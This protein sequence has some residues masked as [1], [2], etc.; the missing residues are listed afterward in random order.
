L[1]STGASLP[2]PAVASGIS[3]TT[4]GE[5]SCEGRDNQETTVRETEVEERADEYPHEEAPEEEQSIGENDDTAVGRERQRKLR[6]SRLGHL[7]FHDRLAATGIRHLYARGG[8]G[9][10]RVSYNIALSTLQRMVI[11]EQQRKLVFLVKGIVRRQEVSDAT[12][13]SAHKLLAQY[14]RLPPLPGKQ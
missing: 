8:S 10:R 12:L 4:P 7:R 1:T 5:P 9:Q 3:T 2:T 13:T 11:H 14:S 6:S